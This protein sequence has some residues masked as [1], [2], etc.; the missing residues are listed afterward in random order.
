M[1][2]VCHNN[3]WLKT[4]S[5]DLLYFA[6][7]RS[8]FIALSNL[9]TYVIFKRVVWSY[10]YRVPVRMFLYSFPPT[11]FTSM[12]KVN[13]TFFILEL[14]VIY[15][16]WFRKI[17]TKK[18]ITFTTCNFTICYKV[19]CYLT[20]RLFDWLIVGFLTSSGKYVINI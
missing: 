12:G 4:A 2:I 18:E 6:W 11:I 17:K 19:T 3:F 15:I 13:Q 7:F 8:I 10:P 1:R 9:G 20:T 14:S 5:S 16:H